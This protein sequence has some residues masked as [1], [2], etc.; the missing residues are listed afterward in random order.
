MKIKGVIFDLDNTLLDF[1]RMKEEAVNAAIYAMI[2]AGLE[3]P[4]EEAKRKIYEIYEKKGI[5]YQEVFDEFLKEV[6]GEIDYRIHAAG[7]VGYRKAREGALALYPHVHMT[8]IELVKRGLKLGVVSD[9]PKKQAWLRLATLGLH[10]L[11]DAV[12]TFEDTGKRKPA[13]EPFELIL[14][15]LNLKPSES[16]MVGDWAERDIVGAKTIG[17][18]TVFARYGDTFGT[19][20]SGADYEIND[21]KELIKIVDE[22]NRD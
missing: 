7:V 13:R 18:V 10:H 19:V 1:M 16:I 2:D 8:L 4:F 22:L 14:K 21:I 12:V 11:F 3:M 6:Y 5:E 9:A 20:N 15:L 17:M